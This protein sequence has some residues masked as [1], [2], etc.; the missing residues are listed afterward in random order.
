[1]K[2]WF[3]DWSN[4]AYY[5][6]DSLK[7]EGFY[8]IATNKSESCAYK[9]NA[10]EFYVEPNL[11]NEEYLAYCL[12]FCKSHNINVFV[13]RKGM[14]CIIQH[15]A[16]FEALNVKVLC[17]SNKEVFDTFDSKVK[18]ASY[19]K[20]LNIVSVPE[21][22][23]ANSVDEFMDA[24]NSIKATWGDVCIK[25]DSN[26]VEQSGKS[27]LPNTPNM[28]K[29]SN[30]NSCACSLD[31]VIDCL[32]STKEFE[33]LVVMP[34]LNG[35]LI[36]VDSF[37]VGNKFIAVP[38][39]KLSNGVTHLEQDS[40]IYAICRELWRDSGINTPF[41]VKFMYHND[42]LYVLG[43]NT[44]L[45]DDAWKAKYVGVDFMSLAIHSLIGDDIEIPEVHF[46]PKDLISMEGVVELC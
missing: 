31:Y 5:F 35:A 21:S 16:E 18:T 7:K 43:V 1:M 32:M 28:D 36:E 12:D 3:S 30:N 10:D 39:Q 25:Y 24:Y 27:I 26:E 19:F 46:Q 44:R 45:S 29:F 40:R 8:V 42:E 9:V 4:I 23:L 11:E 13:P 41:S 34:T 17:E 15:L 38:R 33:S 14:N 2:V 22:I 6:I 37:G 20:D